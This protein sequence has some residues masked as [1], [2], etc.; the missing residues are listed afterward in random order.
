MNDPIFK[1]E[2]G[3]L[4]RQQDNVVQQLTRNLLRIYNWEPVQE[5]VPDLSV[6][7]NLHSEGFKMVG[8]AIMRDVPSVMLENPDPAWITE[9][10][11]GFLR[12]SASDSSFVRETHQD[13]SAWNEWVPQTAQQRTFHNM[14]V[15]IEERAKRE[16]DE[17]HF[18]RG[19][20][21]S[22]GEE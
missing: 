4:F 16:E 10:S 7:T 22:C 6:E 19:T 5:S 14:V 8:Q 15:R 18:A 13:V 3:R 12:G 9:E 1:C 11:G 20:A 2:D 17:Y 21:A